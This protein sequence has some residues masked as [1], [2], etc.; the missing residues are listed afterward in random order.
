MPGTATGSWF[1]SGF[2]GNFRSHCRN[3]VYQE[4]REEARPPPPN[5]FLA[6]QKEHPMKH[7]FS[8]HDNRNI[9]PSSVFSFENGMG[10]RRTHRMGESYNFIQWIPLEDKKRPLISTYRTD[11]WKNDDVMDSTVPQ[12]L[13]PRLHLISTASHQHTTYRQMM[14]SQWSPEIITTEKI[15]NRGIHQATARD[16]SCPGHSASP[17]VARMAHRAR[18]AP[19]K[20]LTVSD[21]LVWPTQEAMTQNETQNS[22]TA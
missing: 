8:R 15:N 1:P 19:V 6:R 18:S 14:R 4:Y 11:F 22:E 10:K 3:D 20:Q 17:G 7:I 9:F 2:H 16:M 5:T 12:L 13:V 21:C